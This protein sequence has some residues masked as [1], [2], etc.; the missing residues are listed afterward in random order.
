MTEK[1]QLIS[2]LVTLVLYIAALF[3]PEKYE[4]LAWVLGAVGTVS[5]FRMVS[6]GKW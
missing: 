2:G 1:N 5:F 3:M 4:A 6:K